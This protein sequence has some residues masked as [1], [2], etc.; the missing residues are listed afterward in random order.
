MRGYKE[1]QIRERFSGKARKTRKNARK[2]LT[3]NTEALFKKLL[4]PSVNS[5]LSVRNSRAYFIF[6]P[7]IQIKT[8]FF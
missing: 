4:H 8:G 3:E 5:V 2:V 6:T 1:V 7:R